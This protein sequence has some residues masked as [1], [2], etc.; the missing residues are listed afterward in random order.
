MRNKRLIALISAAL[1]F[2]LWRAY[3]TAQIPLGNFT[4]RQNTSQKLAHSDAK[5]C[6]IFNQTD[7]DIFSQ[8]SDNQ[9][10]IFSGCD[11]FF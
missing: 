4:S 2:G 5:Q 9:E 11:G 8:K 7:E 10:V 3:N 1:L 6:S